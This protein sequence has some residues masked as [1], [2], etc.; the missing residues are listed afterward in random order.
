MRERFTIDG[1]KRIY[2]LD[3]EYFADWEDDAD[4]ICYE[5]NKFLEKENKQ[6]DLKLDFILNLL[7]TIYAHL[8]VNS[9][10]LLGYELGKAEQLGFNIEPSKSLDYEKDSYEYARK[11]KGA[12]KEYLNDKCD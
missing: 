9:V 2:L 3:G 12:I 4:M 8:D 6:K 11:Y 10:E 1:D 5:V 7:F